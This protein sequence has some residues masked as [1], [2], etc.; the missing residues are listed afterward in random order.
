MTP[1]EI[2]D[3]AT[4]LARVHER[5]FEAK[6]GNRCLRLKHDAFYRIAGRQK[7]TNSVY[8]RIA[9]E[10]LARGQ[11]VLGRD[12]EG[13]VLVPVATARAWPEAAAATLAN[14]LKRKPP[15]QPVAKSTQR[16]GVAKTALSPAAAWPFPTGN[17][18]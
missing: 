3:V 4:R 17:E 5:S 9:S 8:L 7:L 2:W 6:R 15:Q 18:P 14:E 12:D 13:F 11:L 16:K 1:R 10:L